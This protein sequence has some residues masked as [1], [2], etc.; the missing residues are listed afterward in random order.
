M[1]GFSCQTSLGSCPS[2][3]DT[4]LTHCKGSFI[5]WLQQKEKREGLASVQGAQ[6]LRKIMLQVDEIERT[7]TQIPLT[8][9]ALA[10]QAQ[11]LL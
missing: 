1:Q 11:S 9:T 8:T 6:V 4:G 7:H 3:D 2:A 5:A 10:R